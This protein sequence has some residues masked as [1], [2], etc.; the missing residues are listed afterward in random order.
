MAFMAVFLFYYLISLPSFYLFSSSPAHQFSFDLPYLSLITW[1]K[2]DVRV[3]NRRQK[4]QT[5]ISQLLV[6][7]LLYMFPSLPLLGWE[8]HFSFPVGCSRKTNTN[9]TRVLV[10]EHCVSVLLCFHFSFVSVNFQSLLGME[11]WNAR[12]R[13]AQTCSQWPP[14]SAA[15]CCRC[16]EDSWE[17]AMYLHFKGSWECVWEHECVC[18]CVCARCSLNLYL[19]I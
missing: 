5:I 3:N 10:S 15:V 17:K 2:M 8:L 9:S 19:W 18:V 16:S 11:T 12:H 6:F 14:F 7:F 1:L 4:I 13:V